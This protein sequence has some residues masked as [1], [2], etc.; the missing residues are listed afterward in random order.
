M[1][2]DVIY[3]LQNWAHY[4][5]QKASPDICTPSSRSNAKSLLIY[6]SP[7]PATCLFIFV[8]LLKNVE[9]LW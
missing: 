6:L 7:I 5:N 8:I 4:A 2:Y 1:T 9:I 3:N